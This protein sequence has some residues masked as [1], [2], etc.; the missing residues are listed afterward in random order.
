MR[1]SSPAFLDGEF[2]PRKYSQHGENVNPPLVW[3]DVPEGVKTFAL[4]MEDPD[5]PPA[6]GVPV[7][8]H[9]VIWNIPSTM[10][11]IPE[12]WEVAGV[13]GQ[14]TRGGLDYSGPRPPDRVHRYFFILHALD[15][16]LGLAEGSTKSQLLA[17]ME[18]HVF[19][20]AT[21]IGKFAPPLL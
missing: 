18:G 9:W 5:V 4:V 16:E 10:R 14:G 2:I 21:L 1:L 13:R 17:E 3:D 19:A 15:L 12:A 6:A 20:K 7:W 8:D 11:A